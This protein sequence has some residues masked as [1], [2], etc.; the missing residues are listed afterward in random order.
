MALR[1]P[2]RHDGEHRVQRRWWFDSGG[3]RLAEIDTPIDPPYDPRTRRG[4]NN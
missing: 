1:S 2:I 3:V 4:E